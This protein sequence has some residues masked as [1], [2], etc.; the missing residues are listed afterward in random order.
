MPQQQGAG[1]RAIYHLNETAAACWKLIDGARPMDEIRAQLLAA[2]T[3]EP[4]VLDR[5]LSE[6]LNDLRS[7][8]AIAEMPA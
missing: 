6:L 2:Y 1:T 4:D 3:V 5:S 8:E 7:I